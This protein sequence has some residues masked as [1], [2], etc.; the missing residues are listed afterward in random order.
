MRLKSVRDRDLLRLSIAIEWFVLSVLCMNQREKKRKK[1]KTVLSD[2]ILF[3]KQCIMCLL[4]CIDE[5]NI[6]LL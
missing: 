3:Y 5:T 1:K 6:V 2:D 4:C